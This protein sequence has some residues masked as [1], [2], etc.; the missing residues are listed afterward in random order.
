MN[1]YS[2]CFLSD[3][4]PLSRCLNTIDTLDKIQFDIT[5]TSKVQPTNGADRLLRSRLLIPCSPPLAAMPSACGRL[6][7]VLAQLAAPLASVSPPSLSSPL[8]FGIHCLS[9]V[10]GRAR[11]GRPGTA[12]MGSDIQGFLVLAAD[13]AAAIN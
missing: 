3:P 2:S 6:L 1:A 4:F 9:F 11:A 13:L 5:H 12:D 8:L 10:S 7:P